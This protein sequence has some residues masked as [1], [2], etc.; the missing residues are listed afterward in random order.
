MS[1]WEVVDP[2][3]EDGHKID[4][5][6]LDDKALKDQLNLWK[7]QRDMFVTRAIRAAEKLLLERTRL[8]CRILDCG[9]NG[10]QLIYGDRKTRGNLL[11]AFVAHSQEDASAF[12]LAYQKLISVDGVE[13][14]TRKRNGCSRNRSRCGNA[15]S[16]HAR[17]RK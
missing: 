1:D 4:L 14:G 16:V 6:K 15:N 9:R 10:I 2:F 8:E 17:Q 13:I 11:C 12:F 3:S 7:V 5:E